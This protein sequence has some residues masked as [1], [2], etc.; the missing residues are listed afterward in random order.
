MEMPAQ[1][2]RREQGSEKSVLVGRPHHGFAMGIGVLH[3]DPAPHGIARLDGAIQH[4]RSV[5]TGS[6]GQAGR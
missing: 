5:F 3:G 2:R 6:P 1:T 4:S